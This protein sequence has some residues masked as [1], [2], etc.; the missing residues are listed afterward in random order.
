MEQR[1]MARGVT[2]STAPFEGVRSW[3]ES[4]RASQMLERDASPR[5]EVR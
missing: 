5:A 1:L 2:G 4:R 3:F